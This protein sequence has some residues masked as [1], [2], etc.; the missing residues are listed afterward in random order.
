MFQQRTVLST[1]F[2]MDI[3][4]TAPQHGQLQHFPPSLHSG[5]SQPE[6]SLLIH[7]VIQYQKILLL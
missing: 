2:L 4:Q 7:S 1:A 5:I 3:S 6:V